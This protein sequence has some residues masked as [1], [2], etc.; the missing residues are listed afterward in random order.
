[1]KAPGLRL[2]V[3]EAQPKDIL[4]DRKIKGV[5]HIRQSI[6]FFYKRH[7]VAVRITRE[8]ASAKTQTVIRNCHD[9]R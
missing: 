3:T 8:Q 9:A 5:P 2:G 4:T 6:L 7:D 1:M